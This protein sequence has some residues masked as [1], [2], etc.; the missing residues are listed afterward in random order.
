[1]RNYLKFCIIF[2]LLAA[3]LPLCA[4]KIIEYK[5]DMG[6]RDPDDADVWILYRNVEAYHDGMTLYTDSATFDTKNNIFKAYG[7]VTILITDTTT[8]YGSSAIYDGTTRI[9]DVWGDTVTL[10]DGITI[11]KTDLLSY[12][13]NNATASYYHW[14][15]TVHDSALMDSRK[16]HYHSDTRDIYLFDEVVLHDSTAW[17]YT[18]T[19]LYNTRTALAQFISP[20]AI[21][22]DSSTVYSEEG[23]YNTSTHDAASFKA[24]RLTDRQKWMTADT[25]Y[26]ND[27]TDYGRSFGH[28]VI[29]DTLNMVICRGHEGLTS[30][31][32]RLSF[33]TDSALIIYIDSVGDSLF[34]HADTIF[35]Y[36]DEN[37]QFSAA[38]AYRGVRLFRNDAQMVCD[39]L[40]Y[41]ATDSLMTLYHDPVVWYDDYQCTA[42]TIHCF[43]DTAGV[44]LVKLRSNVF[45]IE[46][47]DS[48]KFSQVKGRNADVYL[49]SSEPLYADIL[50][51]ARMVYYVIDEQ[52]ERI[53][54]DNATEDTITLTS[55]SLL[56][57]NAGMGSDMRIYFKKRKPTRFATY[58]SP[59]MKMYPPDKLPADE[60]LLPGFR[61]L[62]DIRPKSPD[63]VFRIV[64]NVS[65]EQSTQPQE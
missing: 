9:A 36:N 40:V 63:D 42:D 34:L 49:E 65:Q 19:L 2:F 1:M 47:V 14:G 7:N 10:V 15:H 21:I 6:S 55:R 30:Q 45:S 52:T 57:V 29:V 28:V 8:L 48:E 56:G 60:R 23:T 12:D 33:V 17:L 18:D 11:L 61:W 3:P 27:R 41:S 43:Y 4:Q 25:L 32:E 20:T 24:S 51:S 46:R 31:E 26:F 59:D 54:P 22:S 64:G 50:G 39:S 16:G 58:V 62:D 37:R 44:R 53:V 35:A 5:A 38:R 13:R